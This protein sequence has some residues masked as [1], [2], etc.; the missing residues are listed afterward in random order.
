MER[1]E[2]EVY[3][4]NHLDDGKRERSAWHFWFRLLTK[5][6]DEEIHESARISAV[7]RVLAPDSLE[8]IGN[9]DSQTAEQIADYLIET[10]YEKELRV[11]IE[12][13]SRLKLD[14]ERVEEMERVV[15]KIFQDL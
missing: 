7:E 15:E 13:K 1:K 12:D 3:V 14:P 6:T 9:W 5:A 10:G 8:R 11:W 2:L 4:D